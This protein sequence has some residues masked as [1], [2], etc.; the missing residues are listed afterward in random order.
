MQKINPKVGDRFTSCD[1][2][3]VVISSNKAVLFKGQGGYEGRTVEV[4]EIPGSAVFSDS[5]SLTG[6]CS[7]VRFAMDT[8][9]AM[10]V[11]MAT[12]KVPMRCKDTL[13]KLRR[14]PVCHYFV[15]EATEIVW[16]RQPKDQA[17][18]GEIESCTFCAGKAKDPNWTDLTI[19]VIRKRAFNIMPIRDCFRISPSLPVRCRR[20]LQLGSVCIEEGQL[21]EVVRFSERLG[22]VYAMP[23]GVVGIWLNA[24]NFEILI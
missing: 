17:D 11:S 6:V 9:V 13:V 1:G 20:R 22:T 18:D 21:V 2:Y 24:E 16:R 8:V 10:L 7:E 14:C 12:D 23:R 5:A 15:A 4:G 19:A 3:G